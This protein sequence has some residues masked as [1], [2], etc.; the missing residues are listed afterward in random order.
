MRFI[1]SLCTVWLCMLMIPFAV[2]G[3][4]D[5]GVFATAPVMNNG[6]RWRIGY[7]EG[8]EYIDYQKVLT[9]TVKGLM[10]LGW[11]DKTEIPAQPG[12]QTAQL[13]Q[14]LN[15]VPSDYIEFVPDA[16]YSA[17]WDE[18]KLDGVTD[19][20]IKR[21]NQH[22][23]DLMIAMGT[24]AG[25]ALSNDRHDTP[26][27][28]LSTSDPLATGIIKSVADSGYDHIH[29]TVDPNRYDRQVRVF[30]DIVGFKNLGVAYENSD[31]GRSY[32]ALDVVEKLSAERGFNIVR[33]YTQSDISD[34]TVAEASVE[35]CFRELAPQV[36]AIYVTVQGGVN[37]Q[38]IASL[39]KIANDNGVPTFSQ[40]GADEVRKGFLLSL[41]QAGFRYVGEFHAQTFAKVFNGAKP[42]QLAQFFEEPPRMAVNLK[43]AEIVGFNPPLLLLGAADEV[44]RDIPAD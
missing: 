6:E 14:W 31:N 1:K 33:C 29:A 24:L 40:S 28:V 34:M 5:K 38:S 2:A 30:H 8:G 17:H 41:S 22:D 43:T 36:D 23:L 16:H 11:I 21:L 25:K 12:E 15:K 20:V 18:S 19:K 9:E 7:F 4:A 3:A 10:A 26:T 32:A 42:N 13:W 27:M 35:K 37:E 39:V 44:Y